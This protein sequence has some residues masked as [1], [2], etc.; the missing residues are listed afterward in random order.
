MALLFAEV[1]LRGPLLAV[2]ESIDIIG[3]YRSLEICFR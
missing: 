1:L 2:F 3:Q